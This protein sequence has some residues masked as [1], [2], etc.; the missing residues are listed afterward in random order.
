MVGLGK[1]SWSL[2]AS[3]TCLETLQTYMVQVCKRR[4]PKAWTS[5]ISEQ[6]RAR[7]AQEYTN[8]YGLESLKALQDAGATQRD[9][10]QQ[11]IAADYAQF[12][13][14]RDFPYKQVQY[15]QSL[16]QDLPI[17]AQET[18]YIEP[19]EF[20]QIMGNLGLFGQ[21]YGAILD[22]P[23]PAGKTRN[24]FGFCVP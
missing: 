22:L 4:T 12:Q 5:L 6:D 7:Q 24:V 15:Q 23:C 19:S 13:E 1:L 17:E 3:A 21:G 11:G 9:I 16:L 10:E 14:E 8:K 2:K 18:S 20:S